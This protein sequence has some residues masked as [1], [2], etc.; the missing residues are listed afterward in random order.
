MSANLFMAYLPGEVSSPWA[1]TLGRPMV[2]VALT[3]INV[4][5]IEAVADA[6]IALMIGTTIVFAAEGPFAVRR[7]ALR[8][9]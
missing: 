7:R 6:S 1:I 2:L 8:S 5:G 3:L 4:A 9:R